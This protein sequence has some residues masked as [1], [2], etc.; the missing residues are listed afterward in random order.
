[1]RLQEPVEKALRLSAKVYLEGVVNICY[2]NDILRRFEVYIHMR[3]QELGGLFA[4][5]R[6]ANG[7]SQQQVA[8]MSGVDRTTVSRFESG[9]VMELGFSKIERLFALYGQELAP[10]PRKTPTLD[11]L[12][13]ER[14]WR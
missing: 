1:M 13:R 2:K 9:R 7:H 6:K 4:E 14:E 10:R 8:A 5:L 12:V 11:D 3:L